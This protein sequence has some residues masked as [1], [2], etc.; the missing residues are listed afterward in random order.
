MKSHLSN[1]AFGILDYLA[2]P[3][4]L[5]LL[6]PVVLRGLGLERFG[7]W[8]MANAV[9]NVGA[10][11]A[12]GFGDANIR[13]TAMAVEAGKRE[14]ILE[15]VRSTLGIHIIFGSIAAVIVWLVSPT[16]AQSVTK[17]HPELQMDCLVSLRITAAL[18]WIRAVET[19]CVSTQRA[20]ARYGSAIQISVAARLLAL[21]AAG[22]LPLFLQAVAAI[23]MAVLFISLAALGVQFHQLKQLL[24]IA[25]LTPSLH[26]ETTTTLLRFGIFTWLQSAGSLL[27][28]QAD[29]IAAGIALGA[30]S[31]SAYV[32]CVQL[33]QPI[34]GLT[35][36]GLH[37]LFPHLASHSASGSNSALRHSIAKALAVNI[38]FVLAA[39]AVLI[40][41]GKAILGVWGGPSIASAASSLLP[42]IAWSAALSAL[43]V[44]GSYT[45]LALGKPRFVTAVNLTCGLAMLALLPFLIRHYGLVGIA[46]ARLLFATPAGLLVYIPLLS[47]IRHQADQPRPT[48]L[49]STY[50]EA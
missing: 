37:F 36:A 38:A 42:P 8:A 47:A 17:G 13:S 43:G 32:F 41:F 16:I 50:K 31:V 15:S 14:A 48:H 7:I 4:G 46:Y 35:A 25:R 24:G 5:L 30:A 9:L 28:G 3:L 22:L 44:T 33:A 40:M 1:A 10:I 20:Y 29:R 23:M 6:A 2:Y 21:I 26:T 19:V 45:L 27:F 18:V 12:S 11:I 34:Y 39:L 49:L